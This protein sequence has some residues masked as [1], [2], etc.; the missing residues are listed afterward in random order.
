M[1]PTRLLVSLALAIATLCASAFAQSPGTVSGR[2]SN[3]ATAQYLGEAEV[4][5]E[6]TA[7]RALTDRDGSYTLL[8]VAPGTYTAVVSYAGL[9]GQKQ[10]L[11]VVAGKSTTQDF[12]LTAGIY[13][14][15]AFVVASEVEGNA[16]QVN[17]QKRADH[18]M[19]AISADTLGEVP[20]GNIG[21]FLKYVPGL[22]VNYSNADAATVS[23]RG[24]DPEA[25]TFTIDGQVP[26]AAGTPPRSS[27][28]SSDASSR[29]FEFTQASITNIE[30]IEV[31]KAPPPWYAPSTGGV[32]NAETKSAFNQKRRVLRSVL[33][34][35][36]N[37]E[38]LTFKAVP[39]PGQRPTQRIKPGASVVYSEAFLSNTLGLTFSYSETNS[40]NPSHNNALGYT[41]I[42]A[43]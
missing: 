15:G 13:K 30:S 11:T 26:A 43:G 29:A 27:T 9:D 39:G 18:F 22:L 2:V 21:E 36:A 10:S 31:Y 35:N 8:N 19:T 25:T 42:V 37:S 28:G 34:L 7:F 1:I 40:I 12:A 41:P 16:A 33:L 32:I 17:K 14:L 38:M 4:S 5:L 23:V 3:Q 20:D 24:Q 6:G